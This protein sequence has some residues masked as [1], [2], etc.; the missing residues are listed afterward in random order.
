MIYVQLVIHP[1][2]FRIEQFGFFSK[3]CDE[4]ENSYIYPDVYDF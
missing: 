3:V 2:K 4:Y 1:H